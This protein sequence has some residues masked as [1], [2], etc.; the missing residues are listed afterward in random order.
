MHNIHIMPRAFQRG[1]STTVQIECVADQLSVMVQ[2]HS[3]PKQTFIERSLSVLLY[4]SD[5]ATCVA[6][7]ASTGHVQCAPYVF[8]L[9]KLQ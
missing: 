1:L 4:A 2:L 7:Y 3:Q 9:R 5:R 6:H 8:A